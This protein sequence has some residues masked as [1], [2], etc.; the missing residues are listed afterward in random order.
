MWWCA[1]DEIENEME[2]TT[3]AFSQSPRNEK[4]TDTAVCI[5]WLHTACI[6]QRELRMEA[7]DALKAAHLAATPATATATASPDEDTAVMSKMSSLS[8]SDSLR[9]GDGDGYEGN[10]AVLDPLFGYTPTVCFESLCRAVRPTF[11]RSATRCG[12][13]AA[14][15]TRW[16]PRR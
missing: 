1:G 2:D 8:I 4:K 14:A 10:E 15:T 16:R 12:C 11:R 7:I 5:K 3:F 6:E 13:C 9:S